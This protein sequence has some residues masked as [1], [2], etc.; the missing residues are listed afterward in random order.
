MNSLHY[1]LSE[2][3]TDCSKMQKTRFR[4]KFLKKPLP[5][6]NT[7][8]QTKKLLWFPSEKGKKNIFCKIK[9]ESNHW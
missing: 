7:L 9:K 6:Q 2:E 4:N 5:K 3:H 1:N 8:Q